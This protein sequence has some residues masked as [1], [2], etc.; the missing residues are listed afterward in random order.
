MNCLSVRPPSVCC[1]CLALAA[2]IG[3]MWTA[4]IPVTQGES[5]IIFDYE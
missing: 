1:T 4:G 5:E 3:Y 2:A